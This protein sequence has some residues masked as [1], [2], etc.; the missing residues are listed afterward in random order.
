LATPYR[1][2][3]SGACNEYLKKGRQV[4]VERRLQ[5]REWENNGR[6]RRTEN[7]SGARPIL[8]CPAS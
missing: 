8:G 5:T 2:K 6:N 7:N 4:F 3:R 1:S